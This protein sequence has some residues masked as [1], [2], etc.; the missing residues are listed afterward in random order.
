MQC[1]KS[2][3]FETRK[4]AARALTPLLTEHSGE[5][6]LFKIIEKIISAEENHSSLNSIHGYML[7]VCIII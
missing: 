3:I 5:S 4:L 1:A 7:Q 6:V 2:A